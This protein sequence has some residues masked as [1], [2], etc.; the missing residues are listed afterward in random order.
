MDVTLRDVRHMEFLSSCSPQRWKLGGCMHVCGGGQ[1]IQPRFREVLK[2]IEKELV[3]ILDR[4]WKYM[5]NDFESKYKTT[6]ISLR[7][8]YLSTYPSCSSEFLTRALLRTLAL[9]NYLSL[10][11]SKQA[12][13]RY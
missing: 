7:F 8:L 12:E 5:V 13:D 3:A 11:G 9:L 10:P 2:T 1:R 6:E 4:T